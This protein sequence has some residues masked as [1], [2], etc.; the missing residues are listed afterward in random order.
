VSVC[1]E[2]R[3]SFP[4][5]ACLMLTAYGDERALFEAIMAGAAG[6]VSKQTCGADLVAALRRVAAGESV[7]DPGASHQLMASLRD[8]AA[9]K[10]PLAALSSQEKRVLDLI[11]EGLTNREIGQ[12]MFL[13]EKTVKNYVTSL[14]TKLGL[15]R[16]TQAVALV[17]RQASERDN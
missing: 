11:G 6:H 10:D 8:H 17:I 5:T 12:R 1:R 16:R 4:E 9:R 7:L 14:L 13:A 2:I 3:S 15:Q